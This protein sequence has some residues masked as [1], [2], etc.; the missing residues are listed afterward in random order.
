MFQEFHK[1]LLFICLIFASYSAWSQTSDPFGFAANTSP[2]QQTFEMSEY[3]TLS[4]SLATGAIEMS[5]PL[6]TYSDP[7]FTVP[8]TADYHYEGFRPSDCSGPLG[9]GWSLNV[10]GVITREIQSLPDEYNDGKLFGYWCSV[11]SGIH[12]EFESLFQNEASNT[13]G[14]NAYFACQQAPYLAWMT[15][16]S[17]YFGSTP[18]VSDRTV[19]YGSAGQLFTDANFS[20]TASDIYHFSIPGHSGSFVILPD[21]DVA[22]FDSDIPSGELDVDINFA[23][24]STFQCKVTINTGDGYSYEFGG[25]R[26]LY[27]TTFDYEKPTTGPTLRGWSALKLHSITAPNGRTLTFNYNSEHPYLEMSFIPEMMYGYNMESNTAPDSFF[28]ADSD[29]VNAN[30]ISSI[31]RLIQSIE[32][33]GDEIVRFHYGDRPYFE[34][35]ESAFASSPAVDYLSH[36]PSEAF[37]DATIYSD[38]VYNR[39]NRLSSISVRNRSDELVDSI[40]FSQSYT[41]SSQGHSSKM[42]LNSIK[43]NF[44][45]YAFT[46]SN[47]SSTALYP[48]VNSEATDHWGFWRGS[49]GILTTGSSNFHRQDAS[50]YN[51]G[52]DTSRNPVLTYMSYGALTRVSYPTGGHSDIEY[53]QNTVTSRVDVN[54]SQVYNQGYFLDECAEWAVG[55]LRVRHISNY[56]DSSGPA[57][58]SLTYD[59]CGSGVLYRMPRYAYALR[60]KHY[61]RESV[62]DYIAGNTEFGMGNGYALMTSYGN[63]PAVSGC[64]K[65]FI[66]YSKVRTVYSDGSYQLT[67]FNSWDNY[68][69]EYMPDN[70]VRNIGYSYCKCFVTTDIQSSDCEWSNEYFFTQATDGDLYRNAALTGEVL[71]DRSSFRSRPKKQEMYSSEG[72]LI[73]STV[74]EYDVRQSAGSKVMLNC[75]SHLMLARKS[76]FQP[77][78]ASVTVR[79]YESDGRSLG[80]VESFQYNSRGQ[81]VSESVSSIP[82]S[83]ER[84]C[85]Y[86]Y[87][88]D[89][90]S[91]AFPSSVSDI[92]RTVRKSGVEYVVSYNHLSYGSDG[93]PSPVSQTIY[94]IDCPYHALNVFVPEVSSYDLVTYS[95]DSM[96]RPAEK[97]MPGGAYVRYEWDA[98]GMYPTKK[99]ENGTAMEYTY[100][101][102]DMIGLSST[103]SPAGRLKR[104]VYDSKGRLH[105][106]RDNGNHLVV[107][108]DYHLATD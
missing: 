83:E 62:T 82:A 74:Y 67:E 24:M 38:A 26:P 94:S 6:F 48:P 105:E 17:V 64:R 104:F 20:D 7:D 33:D 16:P 37:A 3:G 5:V 50:L 86:R 2:T 95:Y 55:G 36:L 103:K 41:S 59:Y 106:I 40:I 19:Y 92:V 93:N 18:L 87:A 57:V 49:G 4:P 53:E 97:G 78:L 90:D 29:H 71:A 99:I 22:V 88:V 77:L 9:L 14:T 98:D 31:S 25:D 89:T 43:G 91:D 47:S 102:R 58:D 108:Y 56:S 30:V 68:P 85:Y 39:S 35:A 46:Y 8:I 63:A 79:R 75:Y 96:M 10:G 52:N 81:K 72:A 101:W 1:P 76:F 60:A 65:R 21:G 12:P 32:V 70:Y 69:D 27:E 13:Y 15:S 54:L 100:T 61:S 66:G 42:F 11:C 23:S 73:S 84:R 44:G 107:K 80:T 28:I 51:L 34:F 45:R